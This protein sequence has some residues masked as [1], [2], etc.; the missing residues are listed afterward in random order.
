[1]VWPKMESARI[2]PAMASGTVNI[3]TNGSTKLSNCAANTR[4]I[5]INARPNAKKVLPLLSAKS[6]ELPDSAVLNDSSSN[7]SAMASISLIPSPMVLPGAK[8]ALMV[9]DL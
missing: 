6:L 7:L 1:M 4:K 3:I 9:A 2:A 5:K 8:P